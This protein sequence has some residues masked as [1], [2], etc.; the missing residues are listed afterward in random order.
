MPRQARF[1]L[2]GELHHVTQRGNFH[3]KVFF[4]DQD[5]VIYLKYMQEFAKKYN[6]LIYAFCLMD[7]HV[8]FL[9]KPVTRDSISKTFQ[10]VQQK[11]SL[12]L[13]KRCQEF[14]HR[15]QARYYSCVVLG[16]HVLTVFRYI[17]RNPV[18]AG[19]VE[20]PWDYA[21]SSARMHLGTKYNIISLENVK[22][23]IDVPSWE[24]YLADKD[25]DSDLKSLRR[26]TY[27]GRIYGPVEVVQVIQKQFKRK[28][29]A[30]PRGR[31]K[32]Q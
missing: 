6:L 12:Y 11:Y 29:L 5:R 28:L 7:N 9:V 4:D 1:V 20:K 19:I 22:E 27:Q 2:P 17:E 3:Q 16:N 24:R 18:R 31:P 13:N 25:N 32:L 15:W 21:W 30:Q 26:S 10:A 14:G 8:H 23:F